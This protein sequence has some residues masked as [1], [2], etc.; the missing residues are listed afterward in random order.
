MKTKIVLGAL[1]LWTSVSFAQT[2][3]PISYVSPENI[4]SKFNNFFSAI[5]TGQITSGI[6][7]DKSP[8]I[9]EPDGFNGF[10]SSSSA[11]VNDWYSLYRRVQNARINSTWNI[12]NQQV[13]FEKIDYQ[14][15]EDRVPLGILFVDYHRIKDGSQATEGWFN[16]TNDKLVD[17]PGRIQNPYEQK[18]MAVAAPFRASYEDGD[19]T[20]IVPEE[21]I[22]SNR[23]VFSLQANFDNGNG[24]MS[25][26]PNTPIPIH[27]TTSG[28]KTISIRVN[29][30]S[31]S[32]YAQT[33]FKINNVF[34]FTNTFGKNCM[35]VCF[36]ALWSD[37]NQQTGNPITTAEGYIIYANGRSHLERPFIF[38]EGQ[39]LKEEYN[40]KDLFY[41]L[42]NSYPN[43]TQSPLNQLLASGYD[44]IILNFKRR[45]AESMRSNSEVLRRLLTWVNQ[46]KQGNQKITLSGVSMGGVIA[47]YTLAKME[48]VYCENHNVEKYFSLDAPHKG[49]NVPLGLQILTRNTNA[50]AFGFSY[51]LARS[52]NQVNAV[53]TMELLSSHVWG[54]GAKTSLGTSFYNELDQL[55]MPQKCRNVAWANGNMFNNIPAPTDGSVAFNQGDEILG[56]IK[57]STPSSGQQL[58]VRIAVNAVSSVAMSPVLNLKVKVGFKKTFSG[59]LSIF[60]IDKTFT[61]MNDWYYFQT[62]KPYDNAPGGYIFTQKEVAEGLDGSTTNGRNHHCIVPTTSAFG[63]ETNALFY[64]QT[65]QNL[66][67]LRLSPFDAVYASGNS[68]NYGHKVL[69]PDLGTQLINEIITPPVFRNSIQS[70]QNQTYNMTGYS[71]LKNI[72]SVNIDNGG[73][74]Q[75]NGGFGSD[76]GSGQIP[77]Q[78]S[79]ISL[80]TDECSTVININNGGLFKIGD[81][82]RYA[83]V[84]IGPGSSVI[85]HDEGT[86]DI[87]WGS[88]LVL[89]GGT[90]IFEKGANVNLQ[91]LESVIEIRDGG[92]ILIHTDAKFNWRGSGYLRFNTST[93]GVSNILA[94]SAGNGAKFEQRI[95]GTGSQKVMEVINGS[96]SV[97]KNLGDFK[98]IS[99]TVKMGQGTMFDVECPMYLVN[100]KMNVI[101]PG[102]KFSGIWVYG[103]QNT[104]YLSACTIENADIGL[105]IFANK[106]TARKAVVYN[107]NFNNCDVGIL[108]YGKAVEIDKG[109]YWGNKTGIYVSGAESESNISNIVSYGNRSAID[110]VG[111]GT[112][113]LNL[114]G[115]NIYNNTVGAFIVNGKVAPVCSKIFNN[116]PLSNPTGGSNILLREYSVLDIEA[117]GSKPAGRDLLSNV[118]SPSIYCVGAKGMFLDKGLTDFGKSLS[119]YTIKG[120]LERWPGITP[121]P[122]VAATQNYW[123]SPFASPFNGIDYLVEYQTSLGT[124]SITIDG[125][126]ALGNNNVLQFCNTSSGGGSDW[127]NDDKSSSLVKDKPD[128][129]FDDGTPIKKRFTDAMDRFYE[130]A[131]DYNLAMNY[132]LSI[133]Q[134]PF[135]L[136]RDITLSDGQS[137]SEFEKWYD[138]IDYS[139]S[140]ALEAAGYIQKRE[141]LNIS[142]FNQLIA[143]NHLLENKTQTLENAA[144][145][146]FKLKLDEALMYRLIDMHSSSLDRISSLLASPSRTDQENM[147]LNYYLC[148]VSK[149]IALK[150]SEEKPLN[151][152]DCRSMI[153]D[154][155]AVEVRG[156]RPADPEWQDNLAK[157]GSVN[158]DGTNETQGETI[159]EEEHLVSIYPNPACDKVYL[160]LPVNTRIDEVQLLDMTG[161]MVTTQKMVDTS[162]PIVLPATLRN[163]IYIVE[164]RQQQN[165]LC[166]KKLSVIRTF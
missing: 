134:Y 17:I 7:M 99:G 37:V 129:Y 33:T 36:D 98:I 110:F 70:I 69:P 106:G 89:A 25:I 61:D 15:S 145:Y 16:V 162:N 27:Y 157:K 103:Q 44:V 81:G 32:Y 24:W 109:A 116:Y 62:D 2:N 84:N 136:S 122:V 104:A 19:V 158:S 138:V 164:V 73:V 23:G 50:L 51:D 14:K 4:E 31:L 93:K 58:N 75:I 9:I 127:G 43:S 96:I 135:G 133:V 100:V 47:R 3:R 146:L 147:L 12:P 121:R 49:A 92:K 152:G 153:M 26:S 88:K 87:R 20:F 131:P 125:A 90:L 141:G 72:P 155:G 28:T 85:I 78:G 68:I 137:I 55:G 60:N 124:T 52:N 150:E 113:V 38:V 79:I 126:S 117:I 86:L 65:Y 101:N 54:N 94:V 115:V 97:D 40:F 163:G 119:P 82:V 160:Q 42:S 76:F 114:K 57:N 59:P 102:T 95:S 41:A 21:L 66:N 35:G 166:R 74:L 112:D 71:Y 1:T 161:A 53:S 154:E 29:Q 107:S 45:S 128:L 64:N 18:L 111:S 105:R 123:G 148:M 48:K 108:S 132:F 91:D 151:V 13:L 39:D 6:L 140:K 10:I 144:D 22:I 165:V 8:G 149:E 11:T 156:E 130:H 5:S 56:Y 80:N 46:Q 159:G 142:D 143:V 83:T 118:H 77:P 30:G 63:V 139:Y 34:T 120:A 67:A